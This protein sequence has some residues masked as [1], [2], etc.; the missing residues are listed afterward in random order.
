MIPDES[1][2]PMQ[3]SPIALFVYD[4]LWHLQQTVESLE[5]NSLAKQSEL[6]IFSD[7]PK[8]RDAQGGISKVRSY[9]KTIR[10]FKRVTVIERDRN[11]GLS[12]SIITGVTE[13]IAQYG[14]VIVLED[15]LV[16]SPYFLEFMN[17]G[18][19]AYQNDETVISICGYMYPLREK[20]PDTLFFRIA[21]CWGWA[22]WK[23]GWDLF[24]ADGKALYNMLKAGN[25]FKKFNLDGAFN[26]TKMLR[27][28]INGKN[29]SWAVRWYASALLND[30]LSLYPRESLVINTGFDGSGRHC[31]TVNCFKAKLSNEPVVANKIP[32]F[33]NEGAVREIGSF[34]RKQR[35]LNIGNRALGF[36]RKRKYNN[37]LIV[38]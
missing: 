6:F 35:L 28:Q 15:D 26:F 25:L 10:G 37:E 20:Y 18:L 22:T 38:S 17:D 7:G 11:L 3:L 33:E 24:M 5:G 23:R 31:G 19:S 32:V 2:L 13:L 12:R 29:D 1:S 8:D 16:V 4:R 27:A 9:I 34:L 30:K 36:F 14:R 21:D